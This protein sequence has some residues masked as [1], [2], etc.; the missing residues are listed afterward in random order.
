MAVHREDMKR[1]RDENDN[2]IFA[3]PAYG[4]A[5]R[6]EVKIFDSFNLTAIHREVE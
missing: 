3:D 2:L 1:M 5:K 6:Q 4:A